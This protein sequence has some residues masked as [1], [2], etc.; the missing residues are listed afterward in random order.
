MDDLSK[1]TVKDIIEIYYR[2]V[3]YSDKNILEFITDFEKLED[4]EYKKEMTERNMNLFSKEDQNSID[5]LK[6]KISNVLYIILN[7][8][9]EMSSINSDL[10]IEDIAYKQLEE[11]LKLKQSDIFDFVFEDL[12]DK[13]A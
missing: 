11:S 1:Y 6:K 8:V 4:L 3:K 7:Q 12:S 9:N 13:V 5:K 2:V 10:P